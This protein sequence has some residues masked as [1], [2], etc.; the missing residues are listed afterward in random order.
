MSPQ[1]YGQA[2]VALLGLGTA[3]L[4]ALNAWAIPR[5]LAVETVV[6]AAT[7]PPAPAPVSDTEPQL[8]PR[9]EPTPEPQPAPREP[10]LERDP[11]RILFHK[12][13]WWVGPAA[14]RSIREAHARIL[15][16]QSVELV[17]H[18]DPSGSAAIN[19]R[20]SANRATA[21]E[22]LLIAAGIAPERIRTRA[23]GAT[24]AT[25]TALD[26]RVEIWIEP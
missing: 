4:V 9:V 13:T 19:R 6:H 23:L 15:D 20:V 12:G 2:L 3:D 8:P 26:R 21:V 7:T 24:H 18:A 1:A 11:A 17:G 5:A 16:S 10:A 25:G 14:R 22:A